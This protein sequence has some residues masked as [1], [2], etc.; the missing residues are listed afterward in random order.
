[1]PDPN[2]RFGW[3]ADISLMGQLGGKRHQSSGAITMMPPV[4]SPLNSVPEQR[5]AWIAICPSQTRNGRASL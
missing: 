4:L 5:L 2:V 1:M 3:K